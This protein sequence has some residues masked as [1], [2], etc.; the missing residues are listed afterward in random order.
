MQGPTSCAVLKKAG[1]RRGRAPEALRDRLLLAR[2]GPAHGVAHGLHRRPGLRI[3][4]GAR[5]GSRRLGRAD[6]GRP[7]A[8]HP[9]HRL[10]GPQHRAHRS[11]IHCPESGFRV[12]R[13]DHPCPAASARRSSSASTGWST[14]RR[15]TS[16]AGARCSPNAPAVRAGVSSGST[17]RATS[18]RTTRCSMPR[19]PASARSAASLPRSGRRLASA[20]S[21]LLWS[22]RR[23]S[24]WARP[25]GP[26]SI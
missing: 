11:G 20:T 16:T 2:R 12:G 4:D 10:A 17:S 3:V 13:A 23:I 9:G 21:R 15:G 14:S 25:S 8:R 26:I 22:M 1:P 6:R 5:R 18:P 7:H 19:R 24:R